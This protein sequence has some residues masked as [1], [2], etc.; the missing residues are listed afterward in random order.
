MYGVDT[1]DEEE[2]VA[3]GISAHKDALEVELVPGKPLSGEEQETENYCGGEPRY[4]SFGGGFADAQ[5]F[6]HG[7][8]LLEHSPTS[9]LD[10]GGTDYQGCGIEPEDG[11]NGGGE[12]LVDVVVI[13]VVATTGLRYEESAD[14]G[15]EEHEIAG[16][17]EEDG[18]PIP[19]EF[20][21]WS[22]PTLGTIIPIVS[23][24]TTAGAFVVLVVGRTST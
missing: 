17:G 19:S 15:D 13:G 24:V 7:M 21:A 16:K 5:P 23:I 10:R 6:L 2:E 18:E 4:G 3:A 11:R 8:S 12:P 22:T 9:D 1:S 20:F 14:D